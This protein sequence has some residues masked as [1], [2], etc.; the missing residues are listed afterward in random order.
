MTARFRVEA[1]RLVKL[2]GYTVIAGVF[3]S[4][5]IGL[6]TLT[7]PNIFAGLVSISEYEAVSFFTFVF[8]PSLVL[9]AFIGYLFATMADVKGM[10]VGRTI[11]LSSMCILTLVV[12]S[13]NI[14]NVVSYVGCLISLGGVLMG[15][16][17]PRFRFWAKK[18]ARFLLG[19][20]AMLIIGFSL[21]F[22]FLAF[23]STIFT[24]YSLGEYVLGGR[25]LI[26]IVVV[27]FLSI[28]LLLSILTPRLRRVRVEFTAALYLVLG[29]I[30]SVAALY[31][32]YVFFNFPVYI[33]VFM[34]VSGIFL[35]FL[36]S[37]VHL[38]LRSIAVPL[39]PEAYP[40]YVRGRFCTF[41]GEL[42]SDSSKSI[43]PGCNRSLISKERGPFCPYCSRV[44]PK[45]LVRCP[46]CLESLE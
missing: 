40:T 1:D 13:V 17:M 23:L 46:H 6:Y 29:I 15:Y 12:S 21:L 27:G 43:C 39:R 20:G 10:G 28:L 4:F 35:V 30:V 44:V 33:G 25:E 7:D 26:S 14:L 38:R 8:I 32:R 31:N 2:G 42:R 18:E 36:G 11:T 16:A 41:C 24:T 37:L 3:I 22:L 34:E 5:T 45:K 9:E 19:L